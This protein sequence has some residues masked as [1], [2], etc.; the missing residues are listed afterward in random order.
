MAQGGDILNGDGTGK[1]S[2]YG[3]KGKGFE[4]EGF[5]GRHTSRGTLSMAVSL[6]TPRSSFWLC[7]SWMIIIFYFE[8]ISCFLSMDRKCCLGYLLVVCACVCVY[9]VY[10][11][12]CVHTYFWGAQYAS[13]CVLFSLFPFYSLPCPCPSGILYLLI[14]SSLSHNLYSPYASI[15]QVISFLPNTS[16]SP[17]SSETHSPNL[18]QIPS[19]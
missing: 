10:G 9:F 6:L 11:C 17:H 5:Q 14:T 8:K 13:L 7:L 3:G 2:I 4:D 19:S 16:L 15:Q 18:P 1:I 12:M